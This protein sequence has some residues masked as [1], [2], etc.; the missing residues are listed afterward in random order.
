MGT[1]EKS[2]IVST[3]VLM[4]PDAF[5]R[6]VD[7]VR[8]GVAPDFDAPIDDDWAYERGRQWALIAPR[9]M[10]LYIGNRINPKAVALFDGAYRRGWI[11]NEHD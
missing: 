10:P 3:E 9:S 7:E 1:N 6:G 2:V 5:R 11:T 4:R 8:S